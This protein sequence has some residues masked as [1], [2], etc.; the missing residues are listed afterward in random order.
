MN[1]LGSGVAQGNTQ[2]YDLKA[3]YEQRKEYEEKQVA[4]VGFLSKL[5][6]LIRGVK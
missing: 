5:S 1:K 4:K 2:S 3:K 6:N